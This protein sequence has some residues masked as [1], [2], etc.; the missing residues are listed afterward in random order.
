VPRRIRARTHCGC[1]AAIRAA[2]CLT[3]PG[4]GQ[5][6]AECTVGRERGRRCQRERATDAHDA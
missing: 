6:A 1:S 2:R 4:G 3:C 5:G